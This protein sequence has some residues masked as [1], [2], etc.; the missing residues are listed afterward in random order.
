M[1][2]KKKA[3]WSTAAEVPAILHAAAAAAAWVAASDGEAHLS[4]QQKFARW[5]IESPLELTSQTR[6]IDQY[7]SLCKRLLSDYDTTIR[8]IKDLI[9]AAKSAGEVR[10]L[11]LAAARALI[12]ADERIDDREE[13]VLREICELIGL[14]RDE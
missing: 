14:P 11:I 7:K 6:L 1:E 4:E 9:R 2:E 8:E 5:L 3:W 12:V 13:V 10:Q